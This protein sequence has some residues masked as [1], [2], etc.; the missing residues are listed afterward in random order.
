MSV[1]AEKKKKK[2]T[3]PKKKQVSKEEQLVKN[4]EELT[5]Q[6]SVI[7]DKHVRLKAEFD[8][9]RKRKEKEIINLIRY[10]GEDAI[11]SMLSIADDLDRVKDAVE[12]PEHKDSSEAIKKGMDLI[13]QKI[14]KL[15]E[16]RGIESFCEVGEILDS[17]FHDALMVREEEGKQENEILEVFEKGYKYKDRI[18][19]HA[20]VVVN[21]A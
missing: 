4:I 1:K 11:K 18:I 15:F 2:K 13:L 16:E 8:N 7:E 21:K 5:L 17:E 9:F 12:H 3:E 6:L 10:E 20:K 19:R 14:H